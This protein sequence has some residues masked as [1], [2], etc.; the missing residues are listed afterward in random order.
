[1]HT[2]AFACACV[3][4]IRRNNDFAYPLTLASAA[5]SPNESRNIYARHANT[6]HR[7]RRQKGNSDPGFLLSSAPPYC[8]IMCRVMACDPA[9]S[10][11]EHKHTAILSVLPFRVHFCKWS[12]HL[13]LGD[14][15]RSERTDV[16]HLGTAV[17]RPR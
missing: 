16:H 14:S 12:P 11:S 2:C 6:L 13:R 4:V 17:F 9:H 3:Y 10:H 8:L 7:Q 1:M 15:V 5:S